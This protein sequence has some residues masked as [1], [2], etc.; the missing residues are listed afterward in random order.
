MSASSFPPTGY[1]TKSKAAYA[2]LT[3]DLKT[4]LRFSLL[5]AFDDVIAVFIHILR[6]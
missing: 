2:T 3:H 6:D 1:G 5:I 4:L